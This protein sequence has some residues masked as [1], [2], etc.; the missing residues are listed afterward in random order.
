METITLRIKDQYA[1]PQICCACGLQA[2]LDGLGISTGTYKRWVSISFP[3]CDECSSIRTMIE[4][5]R[6]VGCWVV[7]G[8]SVIL[9]LS[10]VGIGV[11]FG[12]DADYAGT[13][14]DNLISGL[15]LIALI[16]PIVGLAIQMLIPTIGLSKD[17]RRG[18]KQIY[19][20]V[21][22]KHFK[23]GL[24][25][26]GYITLLFNNDH[27]AK[28]FKEINEEAVLDAIPGELFA[29]VLL[30]I[31]A[32]AIGVVGSYLIFSGLFYKE[33]VVGDNVVEQNILVAIG[34]VLLIPIFTAFI[35]LVV[36][37]LSRTIKHR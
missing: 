32:A 8:L 35:R 9:C 28:Y 20:A 11:A 30:F 21:R 14:L 26:R 31:L 37:S 33:L 12:V 13:P 27:F 18:Y 36:T 34:L 6:R 17:V 15:L 5:R 4:R 29:R 25:G 10:A 24:I 19:K 22:I 16:T 7:I 3:L 2:G 1:M 23:R